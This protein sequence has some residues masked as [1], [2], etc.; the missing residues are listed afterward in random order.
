MVNSHKFYFDEASIQHNN[1]S[2]K[3]LFNH[4]LKILNK[5]LT[6]HCCGHL[7]HIPSTTMK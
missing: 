3:K 7:N 1:K 4:P 5:C 2:S 6:I